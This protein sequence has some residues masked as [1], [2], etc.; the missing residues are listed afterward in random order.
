MTIT[1]EKNNKRKAIKQKH[2]PEDKTNFLKSS[3]SQQDAQELRKSIVKFLNTHSE[4]W[5]RRQLIQ[6]RQTKK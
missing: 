4:Y 6:K 3:Y 2:L 5:K 1:H